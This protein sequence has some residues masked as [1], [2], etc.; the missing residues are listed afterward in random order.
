MG[1]ASPQQGQ[2]RTTKAVLCTKKKTT[3]RG[4]GVGQMYG[5]HRSTRPATSRCVCV[6]RCA[7]CAMEP[8]VRGPGGGAY[9]GLPMNLYG[10]AMRVVTWGK[11]GCL[12]T[13]DMF[14]MNP[15]TLSAQRHLHRRTSSETQKHR[16]RVETPRDR[17]PARQPPDCLLYTSPSPRDRG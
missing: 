14:L 9:Y 4:G 12:E 13:F 8:Q 6:C 15:P 11:G 5:A 3:A 7:C 10:M 16:G 17:G 1:M 2:T